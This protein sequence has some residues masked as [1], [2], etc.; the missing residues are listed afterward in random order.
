ML[1]CLAIVTVSGIRGI[2]NQD[3]DAGTASEYSLKFGNFLNSG[4]VAVATDTRRTAQILK[5]AVLSGLVLAGCTVYDLG[6]SSTPSVFKEVAMKG[7]DGGMI[8]TASHNPPEWNGMK[9][10]VSGGRGVFEDDLSKIQSAPAKAA[11]NSGRVIRSR[12]IYEEILRNKAGK[13]TAKGVKLALD[14]AGGVGSLFIPRLL[15]YQGCSVHYIHDTPGI[16][17]RIIDPTVDPLTALSNLVTSDACD[18][19]LA[20]DCDADRLVIVDQEGKKLTGD[21]TLLICLRYFLENSRNRNVAISVDTTLAAEDLVREYNGKVVYSKVGEANVVRKLIENSCGAGGEGSSGGYIEPGFV[22]CRDG[23]YASTMLAKMIH[24][25]GA[26]KDLLASFKKYHQDR[27]KI[28][29]KRELMGRVIQRL[30][31]T[32]PEAD[33]TDGLKIRLGERAWVLIRGSNTENVMRVSAEARTP[34][35][36]KQLVDEYSKRI[37]EIE[38]EEGSS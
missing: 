11:P 4:R 13:D 21:A 25:E 15:S 20:F 30:A 16:F 2:V 32:E 19:G 28:E 37:V 14:L 10:I 23:V 29:I 27:T 6:Y 8:V 1:S 5:S 34:E 26:L 7:L 3:I 9:F 17:P 12:A 38:K 24:S 33:L 18:A 22:M 35:R 31:T 36:A